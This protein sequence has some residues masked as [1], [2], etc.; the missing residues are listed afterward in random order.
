M[1]KIMMTLAIGLASSAAFAGDEKG[2][3]NF[4]GSVY[5]GGTCPIEVVNPG[6]GAMPWVSLGNYTSK[7]FDATGKQTP[8]VAFGL[9]VTPDTICTI[10]SN[11]KAKVTFESQHGTA[12]GN[13]EYYALQREGA[14]NLALT[15]KD[16]AYTPIP[17]VTASKE[18]DLYSNQPTDLKFYAAYVSTDASVGEGRAVAEVSFKVELP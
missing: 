10:P 11:S 6:Q 3:I 16:D 13:N 2:Y 1:K 18:Y 14:T 8:D 4:Q 15:I 7:Y 5:A 9:R 17:P 12:G